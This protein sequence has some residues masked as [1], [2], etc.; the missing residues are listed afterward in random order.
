MIDPLAPQPMTPEQVADLVRR[1]R[2]ASAASSSKNMKRAHEAWMRKPMPSKD[3]AY[4]VLETGC[5][6]ADAA[7]VHSVSRESV[8]Y[9]LNRL[10]PAGRGAA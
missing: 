1:T 4:Q 9:H 8:H 5:S 7:R 3:A 10:R 6:V 2:E